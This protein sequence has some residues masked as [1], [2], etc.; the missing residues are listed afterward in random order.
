MHNDDVK[1]RD[2]RP[3]TK[4]DLA[5]LESRLSGRMD[6]MDGRMDKMDGRMERTEEAVRG[7][8][9]ALLA[10]KTEV[11]ERFDLQEAAMRRMYSGIID[12]IDGFMSKTIKVDKDQTILVHR[13]D[14]LEG[15]VSRLEARRAA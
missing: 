12:K 6:K 5:D 11:F 10:F 4:G 3:A 8:A 7:V 9:K 14:K 13:V 1:K 15:R 2:E